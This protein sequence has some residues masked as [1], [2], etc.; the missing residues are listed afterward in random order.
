MKKFIN[1]C[2]FCDSLVERYEYS[3]GFCSCNAK[4]YFNDEIW[5]NRNTGETKKK[6]ET[7]E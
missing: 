2:P 7:D 4:Y 3:N 5:F 6:L 1:K